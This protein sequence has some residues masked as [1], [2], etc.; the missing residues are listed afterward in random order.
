L[1]GPSHHVY[2]RRCFLSTADE[3]AT[4]LGPLPID[5]EVVEQLRS[6]GQFDEMNLRVD[7]AEHS[8]ELHAS[9]IASVMRGRAFT[10]VPVMVGAL[11]VER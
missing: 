9:F 4:P 6:T 11:S 2:S 5:H 3:Y 8:L 10:L 1:L 7:E